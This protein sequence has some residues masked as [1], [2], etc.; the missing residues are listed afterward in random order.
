MAD[1]DFKKKLRKALGSACEKAGENAYFGS[2]FL[3]GVEFCR[4]ELSKDFYDAISNQMDEAAKNNV[5][6]F[7][8][9]ISEGLLMALKIYNKVYNKGDKRND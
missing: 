3:L 7:A 5:G 8:D 9:G 4:D 1:D 6:S 2:G